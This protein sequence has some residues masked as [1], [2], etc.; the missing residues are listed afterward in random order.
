MCEQRFI[1]F[2]NSRLLMISLQVPDSLSVEDL[3]GQN[4]SPPVIKTADIKRGLDLFSPWLQNDDRQSFL[5]VGPEG[6]GKE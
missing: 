4:S 5:L 3:T 6:C 1:G 2:F